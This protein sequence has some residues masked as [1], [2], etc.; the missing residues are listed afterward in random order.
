[1]GLIRS[2]SLIGLS[3]LQNP[4]LDSLLRFATL[5]FFYS[6]KCNYLVDHIHNNCETFRNAMTTFTRKSTISV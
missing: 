6:N 2:N 3:S 1:M 4:L 5:Y